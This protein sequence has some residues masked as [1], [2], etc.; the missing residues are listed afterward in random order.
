MRALL[1]SALVVG[2]LGA[3]ATKKA[4]AAATDSAKSVSF[5]RE[6]FAY[7]GN[8]R[9]DP[10]LSPIASGEARPILTDLLVTGI[11]F[12]P[13]GNRSVG[14]MRDQSTKQ[15]YRVKVGDPLG[16]A[17]VTRITASMIYVTVDEFGFARADSLPLLRKVPDQ[18]RTP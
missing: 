2:T 18:V 10:F 12:D 3:Q 8:G 9:R 4:P 1:L 15:L 6:T 14:V 5:Q 17:R 7:D 11:I 13:S 16:R